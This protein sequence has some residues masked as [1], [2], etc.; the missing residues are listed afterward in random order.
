M[1]TNGVNDDRKVIFYRSQE[2]VHKSDRSVIITAHQILDQERNGRTV[3]PAR[4]R[5]IGKS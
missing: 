5:K 3:D 4:E 2:D 1:A